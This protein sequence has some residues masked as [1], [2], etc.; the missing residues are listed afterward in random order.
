MFYDFGTSAILLP[1]YFYIF[2]LENIVNTGIDLGWNVFRIS[3][4]TI[5]PTLILFHVLITPIDMTNIWANFSDLL[6]FLLIGVNYYII[7]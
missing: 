6:I 1:K 3:H 4:A 2:F 5:K 7:A